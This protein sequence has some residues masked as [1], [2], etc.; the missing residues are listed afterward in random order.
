MKKILLV[1]VAVLGVLMFNSCKDDAVTEAQLVNEE[2][3]IEYSG[4][5]IQPKR[6]RYTD[7]SEE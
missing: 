1:V 4:K 7:Y 5:L 2:F 6:P 3:E